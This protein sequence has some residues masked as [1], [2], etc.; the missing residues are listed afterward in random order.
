MSNSASRN[1]GAILFLTTLTR[2]SLPTTSSPFLIEPM[3][4][5]SSR[6]EAPYVQA[7]RC[8]EFERVA[9]GGRFRIAEHDADFHPDLVDEDHEHVGALDIRRKLAQRLA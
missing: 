7:L 8:V 2:V 5:M 4:R 9:A 1:G 6:T 3:R